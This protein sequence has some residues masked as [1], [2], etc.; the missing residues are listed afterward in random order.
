MI[1][2]IIIK[3]IKT[4]KEL[5]FDKTG[6]SGFVID[7]MDWDV[8]SISNESYRIPFQIGETLSSTIIGTRKPKLTGY[9][10]SNKNYPIGISWSE[11]YKRQEQDI[12][13]LKNNLNEF[14]TINNDYEIIAGNYYLKCRLNSPVKYSS[15]ED[16]NNDVLC[17]FTAEFTCY[18]PMF[19]E[20]GGNQE[21]Y[22]EIIKKFMFPLTIPQNKGVIIGIENSVDTKV[23]TNKGNVKCGFEA[24]LK[25]K[26]GM[27]KTPSIINYTTGERL[28][29][30]DS[31]V[32]SEF[33]TD[34]YIYLNTKNGEEDIYYYDVSTGKK[35][36]L[37]GELSTNSKFIQL[38][39]GENIVMYTLGEESK[40]QID[41]II[42][43]DNQYFNIGEM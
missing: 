28:N 42:Y 2:E 7:E 29:I 13:N 31:V 26:N 14:L 30:Y 34:D 15:S 38:D 43:Y 33:N 25:V 32:A 22:Y 8:P 5:L 3:N 6:S 18:N 35:I 40:G 19:L 9:V 12:V 1:N 37:I 27:I 20:V 39:V 17:A 24:I 16:E 21:E 36:S 11:Y 10:I 23:I 4:G 41:L